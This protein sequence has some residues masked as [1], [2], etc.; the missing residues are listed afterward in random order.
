MDPA[1]PLR[2]IRPSDLPAP[3]REAIRIV[4]ACSDPDIDSRRLGEMI[5]SDPVLTAELLRIANSALFGLRSRVS[6]AAH[7][8]T[9]LGHRALRN[10]ALC[11]AMRDALKGGRLPA[12]ELDRF[13]ES[14]LRRAVSARALA[15]VAN[16][17]TDECFT[18]G[19]IQDFGLLVL[20]WLHPE[21]VPEWGRL[22]ATDPEQRLELERQLFDT[23]HDRVGMELAKVWELPPSLADAIAFHHAPIL[24]GLDPAHERL[25]RV[26]RC[27]DWMAALFEADDK[28]MVFARTLALLAECFDLVGEA[29]DGV[30]ARVAE[31]IDEAAEA[32]G[33]RIGDQPTLDQVLRDA[34]LRLAE[35]NLSF[36]ELT[37]RLE[38]TL[39]ERDRLAAQLERELSLAREVQCGLLPRDARLGVHGINLPAHHLSGDFYD[40]FPSRGGRVWFAIADVSGKGMH[41]ALLMAKTSS[42]LHCLGKGI[43][44]P[45]ALF[46]TL[47]RELAEHPIR[48]M[49]VSMAGGVFDPESGEGV[50]V[51]AGHLPA[52][53]ALAE[54]TC[55]QFPAS[56]PPLGVLTGS[57]YTPFPFNL[58]E[59]PLLLYTDGVTEARRPSGEE[60]GIPGLRRL[61]R[62]HLRQPA[63]E[64]LQAM[65]DEIRHC[66]LTTHDDLTLLLV[67]E[68]HGD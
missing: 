54:G 40:A 34:N 12:E 66:K 11:I 5:T 33:M 52:L 6:S 61:L 44:D 7:A 27:A 22:T 59:G 36:Q 18:A 8:V 26:T 48:G 31:E 53:Q 41:A 39:A 43:T 35:E 46:A 32:L 56:G 21:R 19:L 45:A 3:P 13:W 37:W 62:S 60:L 23:T 4:R 25:A 24:Q 64:R 49:F 47:N 38:Q 42:L 29:A 10:L 68:R 2:G 20:L 51:N 28:R 30:L 16:L 1:S 67:E 65:M 50:L 14:A 15:P 55:R 57:R 9:L 58:R 63:G 17:E